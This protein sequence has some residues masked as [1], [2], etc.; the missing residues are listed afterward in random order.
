MTNYYSQHGEDFLLD[1]MF[2]GQSSGFFVEVGCIDGKR[3]SNTLAFEELGWRGICV[4]A[5]AGYIE[6]L[7][8]N[9]P[10]SV[11]VHCA[12]GDRDQAEVVFYANSRGSLSTLDRSREAQFSEKYASFFTGFEE[13]RT[14]MKTLDTIF[15]ETGVE[16]IDILSIDI[17]GSEIQA[18]RGM[19]FEKYR[20]QVLVIES[21]SRRHEAELDRLLL[22]PG[23]R[24]SVKIG[25]NIFYVSAAGFP[26]GI[27]KMKRTVEVIHTAHPLDGGSDAK[28]LVVVDTNRGLGSRLKYIARSAWNAIS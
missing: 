27:P 4:E 18:L 9:R 28:H 25:P 16:K 21:D 20:P 13:Q 1:T 10:S 5:H 24:K 6:L 14:P 11:V 12:V 22:P 3:Y 19:S 7:R 23:Y 8:K 15:A 17:E 26:S 2:A